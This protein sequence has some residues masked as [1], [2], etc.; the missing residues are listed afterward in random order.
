M[1]AWASCDDGKIVWPGAFANADVLTPDE[2]KR[3]ED[4]AQKAVLKAYRD[5]ID[6]DLCPRTAYPD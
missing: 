3:M 1:A 2:K 6:P 4:T 5:Q